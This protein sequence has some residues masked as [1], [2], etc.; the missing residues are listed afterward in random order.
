[1]EAGKHALDIEIVN[2]CDVLRRSMMMIEGRAKDQQVTLRT[3]IFIDDVIEINADRR[4]LMQI[5]LN[6]LS[7][8]VKFTPPHGCVWIEYQEEKDGIILRVCDTGIGIPAH[9]LASVLKPFEQVE[10][11]Y[12]KEY[13]GTGLG[14]SITKELIEMHGGNIHISSTIGIGTT[15]SVLL[16]YDA[17]KVA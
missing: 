10:S 13:E 15:V 17:P 6:L 2:V 7:N 12:T 14:L 8:A 9:K 3:P 16:P 11:H 1:M 5:F 4:A